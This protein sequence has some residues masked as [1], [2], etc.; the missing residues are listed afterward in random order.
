MERFEHELVPSLGQVV[1]QRGGTREHADHFGPVP[2]NVVQRAGHDVG[3]DHRHQHPL[4]GLVAERGHRQQ[5]QAPDLRSINNT[6]LP[7]DSHR[8]RDRL[9]QR[10]NYS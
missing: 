6:E 1:H 7:D 9:R 8:S 2:G 3:E 5:S 4:T 10:I